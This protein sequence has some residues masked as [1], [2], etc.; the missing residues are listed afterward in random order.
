[1]SGLPVAL[2][3]P[4]PP[5]YGGMAAYFSALEGGLA[6]EGVDCERIEI[7]AG[8]MPARLASF[9]RAAVRIRRSTASVFHC[10]TGSHANLLANGMLLL[11]SGRRSVLTIG[12]GEFGGAAA[13]TWLRRWL[14]RAVVSRA[15]QIVAVN[16]EI[17][18]ALQLLGLPAESV[19]VLSNALPLR[20]D[21]PFEH[22]ASDRFERF[23]SHRR[24]LL[25]SVGAWHEHY[26]SMDLLRAV[27]DLRGRHPSIGLVL[28]V[29]DGGDAD[30]MN[31]VLAWIDEQRLGDHVVVLTNVPGIPALMA[32]SDVF[33][34]TPHVEGD[35][36]S[37]R[38]ALAVGVPVV[39]SDAGFRPDGVMLYRPADY[40]DLAA[41]LDRVLSSPRSRVTSDFREEGQANLRRL[42]E[43]Y[44][45]IAAV[46]PARPRGL[47]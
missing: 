7:E 47:P 36:M 46:A 33:V 27:A 26:G 42:I 41:K 39:A 8:S 44:C 31:A 35:S 10:I 25:V 20:A 38:E 30:F 24:P 1:M 6:T 34:R 21:D 23:A 13:G 32:R 43:T 12:G 3:G 2:V 45:T 16:A 9:A 22:S 4:F 14:T 29:K 15:G 28:V 5:P 37:V 40:A 18:D 19:I 11:A 17:K